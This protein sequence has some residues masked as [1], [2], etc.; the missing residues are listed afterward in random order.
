MG[1]NTIS[2]SQFILFIK[3]SQEAYCNILSPTHFI[4]TLMNTGSYI[5]GTISSL[6]G[7][8]GLIKG[9]DIFQ[10]N[11]SNTAV[12]EHM[13]V[14]FG[15]YNFRRPNGTYSY[16]HAVYQS[17]SG[18]I[19]LLAKYDDQLLEGPNL[20]SMNNKWTHYAWSKHIVK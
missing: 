13:G 2:S 10:A 18:R 20:T 9:M 14:Y 1:Y 3:V 19:T 6:G 5:R 12:K 7:Y 4:N 11:P 17:T 8:D 16:E 15:K